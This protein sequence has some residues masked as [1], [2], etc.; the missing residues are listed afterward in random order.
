MKSKNTFK[1]ITETDIWNAE[2]VF[3]LKT[4]ISRLSKIIY[5]YEIYKKIENI[6]GDFIELGVFKGT[7]FTRFLTFRS[8]IENNFSRRFY[9]FDIFGKFPQKSDGIYN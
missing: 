9:G 2:N 4:N 8:I 7:S 3:H 6:P 5:Q 1:G